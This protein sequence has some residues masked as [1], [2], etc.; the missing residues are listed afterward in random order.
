MIRAILDVHGG[1]F[2]SSR[3]PTLARPG[4]NVS[5]LEVALLLLLGTGTTLAATFDN[6][7]LGIPGHAILWTVFP[8]ALGLA[9]VPRRT[10][11]CMMGLSALATAL[12]LRAMGTSGTG[13]GAMTSLALTGPLLDLALWRVEKGW[14]LYL[15][16]ALAGL[17]SNVAAFFVSWG[18]RG[19]DLAHKAGSGGGGAAWLARAAWT[20][21]VCG[22]LAGLLS[23]V[24]WFHFRQ[25]QSEQPPRDAV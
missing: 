19:I 22:L 25:R 18:M 21:P 1:L 23:A 4:Q 20:Y 13:V 3:M 2:E 17:G 12:G 11:G 6:F 16:F 15:G 24:V 8:T 7:H 5:A 9:V 10:S 14:R